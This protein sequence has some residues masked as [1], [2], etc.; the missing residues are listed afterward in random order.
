MFGNMLN[1]FKE[2]EKSK[3]LLNGFLSTILSIVI[4][5]VGQIIGG[6]VFG[7][8]A[9]SLR[10]SVAIL[11]TLQLFLLSIFPLLLLFI[12]VKFV[13]KRRIRTLGLG[14]DNYLP[15]FLVG[16]GIGFTMFTFVTLLMYISGVIK[17]NQSI[18]AGIDFLPGILLVLPGWI[19]QSSTEEI[20]SR[21]W[22]MHVIGARHNA[23]VGFIV[24]SV[25]FGLLHI[26]NPGVNFISILNIVLV[27]LMLGLYVIYAKDLWGVCGLH[28]AWNFTQGNIYGF[29]VSGLSG[30]SNSLL[31][32]TTKGSDL[33]TGGDFG[34][35]ASIFSTIVLT[36]GIII[37][38]K[39]IYDKNY[40]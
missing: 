32:F 40:K 34:P 37:L 4:I 39:M 24:S 13:E 16:F 29:S 26:A 11:W 31:T 33:M 1:L 23:K 10:L 21:G 6:I 12:W 3:V 19:F 25:L 7:I 9:S 5:I 15:K 18:S 28:A 38:S 35:E 22:L 17:L 30:Y 8:I 14:R 20:I 2:A 36:L 27:G